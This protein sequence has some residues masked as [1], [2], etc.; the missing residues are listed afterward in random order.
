MP[1]FP[2][3]RLLWAGAA[4]FTL[5]VAGWV[6]YW[7]LVPYTAVFPVDLTVYL[8]GGLIVRE[9]APYYDPHAA[10]PLYDWGGYS[11]LALKFTYTPF[12]AVAFA[13]ASFASTSVVT[14]G[15]VVVSIAG[16]AGGLWFTL[17]AL[18]R[19]GAPGG[20]VPWNRVG[21][22]GV[23]LLCAGAVFWTQPVLRNL[24]LGQVNVVLMALI[25]WDLCQPSAGRSGNPRWWKG[26]GT[27]VAAGIKLV[28]LVFVPYLLATR[29]FREAA[30][31]L[32]GFV[33]TI[34]LG[35]A[36]LPKDSVT[37]WLDG[38]FAKGSRTGFVG[39][40]GNQSLYALI[41]RLSGSIA[42]GTVPWLVVAGIVGIAGIA[43]AAVLSRAGHEVPALLLTA[44]TGLLVS[45]ISW[46]HH[47][48]WI[49]PGLLTAVVY[50]R[51]YWRAARRRAWWLIGLTAGI[52]I[53][54]GAW[55][56][57]LWEKARNL[58]RFSLGFLWAPPNTDPILYVTRGDQPSF[59]EYH[60]HGLWLL[61]GNAYILAGLAMFL[62]LCGTALAVRRP[63]ADGGALLRRSNARPVVPESLKSAT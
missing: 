24:N 53:V 9:V 55:P 10:S 5:A 16:L 13:L 15:S 12:A 62:A 4:A 51:R 43:A 22:A 8:D 35:F 40:A 27:G 11:D 46:D 52:L 32:A 54:F 56:D 26:L 41:T 19:Q 17:G 37:W 33:L 28:P 21:R 44:L 25:M 31:T 60:W 3:S 61:A 1:A 59:V 50:A 30:L 18:A 58:G 42:A 29:R 45:P 2:R 49:A 36:V 34:A 20:L 39:W 57:A 47:W 6:A 63:G 7:L 14:A 38:V 48:V 23:T